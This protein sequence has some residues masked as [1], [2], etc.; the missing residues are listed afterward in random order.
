[1]NGFC[2][3]AQPFDGGKFYSRYEEVLTPAIEVGKF[4]DIL[5]DNV[6]VRIG[7]G[8]RDKT[9]RAYLREVV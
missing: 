2:F 1:M 4:A 8:I 3:V 6:G 7:L 5:V 9:R